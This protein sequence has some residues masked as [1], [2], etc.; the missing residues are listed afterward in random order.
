MNKSDTRTNMLFSLKFQLSVGAVLLIGLAIASISYFLIE[1]QKYILT[2]DLKT[3]IVLQARNVALS[4]AKSLLRPDPEFEL[5]PLVTRITEGNAD[6]QM[7]V[8]SDANGVVQ[9]DMELQ[10]IGKPLALDLSS[11][12]SVSSDLLGDEEALARDHLRFLVKTPIVSLD[13]VIG[14]VYMAYSGRQLLAAIG[15][16]VNITVTGALIAFLVGLILALLTFRRISQPMDVMM[17]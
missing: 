11:Y 9:A 16:S 5:V 15:R 3:T 7:L 6:I 13:K 10:N 12:P 8:I 14:Y 4:S 2:E 17:R 1:H